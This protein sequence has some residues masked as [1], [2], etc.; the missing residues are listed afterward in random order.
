MYANSYATAASQ[1]HCR[2]NATTLAAA[3]ALAVLLPFGQGPIEVEPCSKL[4]IAL[5]RLTR[6]LNTQ[7]SSLRNSCAFVTLTSVG[8]LL[9]VEAD[10]LARV[11]PSSS[12]L[13]TPSVAGLESPTNRLSA[14]GLLLS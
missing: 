8:Q 10:Q 4:Y 13:C 3:R 2:P 9:G 5:H 6:G 1:R 11:N 12:C 7:Q 14:V